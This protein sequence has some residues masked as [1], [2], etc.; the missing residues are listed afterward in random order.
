MRSSSEEEVVDGCGGRKRKSRN[1][2]QK[3]LEK[4]IT[5]KKASRGRKDEVLIFPIDAKI[6]RQTY[7]RFFAPC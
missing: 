1:R 6:L 4:S 3:E 2:T 5:V 7:Q